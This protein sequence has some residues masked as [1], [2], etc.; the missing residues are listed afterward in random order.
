MRL[1][2]QGAPGRLMSAERSYNTAFPEPQRFDVRVMSVADLP[3]LDI[4]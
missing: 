3:Q 1:A 2:L 4:E